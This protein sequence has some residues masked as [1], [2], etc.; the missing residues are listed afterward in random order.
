VQPTVVTSWAREKWLR[1]TPSRVDFLILDE[2]GNAIP[3]TIGFR[4][5][6]RTN[7]LSPA[8]TNRI[9]SDHDIL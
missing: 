1:T 5:K 2:N 9:I 8:M 6:F 4:P 7:R 3:G